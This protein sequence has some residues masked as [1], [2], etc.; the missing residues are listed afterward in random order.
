MAL[1]NKVDSCKC[2][3][4]S[5]AVHHAYLICVLQQ[6]VKYDNVLYSTTADG[7]VVTGTMIG[8]MLAEKLA[9]RALRL[10]IIAVGPN[11][12]ATRDVHAGAC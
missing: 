12:R 11:Q 1:N 3:I 2:H 7:V 4:E 8:V 10:S 9:A 5:L 6:K